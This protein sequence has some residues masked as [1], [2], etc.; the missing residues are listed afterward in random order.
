MNYT[1]IITEDVWW[2]YSIEV[3]ELP[4]CISEWETKKEAIDNIKEAIL[5]YLESIKEIA[6]KKASS[7]KNTFVDSVKVNHETI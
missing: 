7:M 6:I 5:L 4:W 1:L 2:G 3:L